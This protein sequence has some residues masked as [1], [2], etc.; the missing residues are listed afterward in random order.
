MEKY[1]IGVF[2][3]IFVQPSF[4]IDSRSIEKLVEILSDKMNDESSSPER[5]TE[6]VAMLDDKLQ[7]QNVDFDYYLSAYLSSTPNTELQSERLLKLL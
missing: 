3:L 4:S 6:Q 5:M 1:F 7:G 2:L